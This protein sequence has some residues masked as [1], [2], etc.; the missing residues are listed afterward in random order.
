MKNPELEQV[1]TVMVVQKSRYNTAV[2]WFDRDNE[3]S[4]YESLIT[5]PRE[6]YHS[7]VLNLRDIMH[8]QP[9]YLGLESRGSDRDPAE[10]GSDT[11]T[12]APVLSSEEQEVAIRIMKNPSILD[13]F[14]KRNPEP[15]VVKEIKF[16][17]PGIAA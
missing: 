11:L 13:I 9:D 1:P 14:L 4:F 7:L 17:V 16:T 6:T 10:T 5:N 8:R 3:A 2:R 15:E 12:I